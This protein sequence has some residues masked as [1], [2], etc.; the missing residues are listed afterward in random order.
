MS[1]LAGEN[2]KTASWPNVLAP[3]F[4]SL[5]TPPLQLPNHPDQ[6]LNLLLV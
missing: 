1:F 3:L 2:D 6:N 5:P 4:V